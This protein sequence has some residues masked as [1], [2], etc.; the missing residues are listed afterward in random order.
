LKVVVIG[1]SGLIG[2]R[3]VAKLTEHGHVAIAASPE[4]GVNT[5]TGEGLGEV[6]TAAQVVV[7]VSNSPSFEDGPAWDFFTTATGNLLT[8]AEAAGVSHY[9]ALSVVG[10]DR[11]LASGY[12]RAKSVQEKLISEAAVPF[13][14]VHATQFLEF[15]GRIADSATDGDT[16]R[17]SS[18]LSQPM[19]ADDVAPTGTRS[20][21]SSAHA[22]ARRVTPAASSRI[23]K[24]ASSAWCSMTT[25]WSPRRARRCSPPLFKDWLI[26]NAPAPIR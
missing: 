4:T 19:V 5:L 11:L 24:R 10:T 14:I 20:T 18:A 2:S 6:L 22:S 7:D 15:V 16:V 26:E 12:F 23:R 1:G 25:R 17:I 8:A 3:V 9:V 13:S 21:T